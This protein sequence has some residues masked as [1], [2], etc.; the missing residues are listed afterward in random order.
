MGYNRN[1]YR[2]SSSGAGSRWMHLR[3]AGTCQ[4]CGQAI[5]KGALAYWD[6]VAKT[7]TCENL[8]CCEA[9]GLTTNK[10][11]TGPWDQRTDLRVARIAAS[12]LRHPRHRESSRHDSTAA[13]PFTATRAVAAIDAPACGCCS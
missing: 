2:R 5:A 3:Y 10:P 7:V 8:D 6:S 9:D 4:V 11:L 13:R 1:G 12:V